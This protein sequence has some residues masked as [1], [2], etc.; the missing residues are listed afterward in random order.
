MNLNKKIISLFF[1][2]SVVAIP[3][4]YSIYTITMQVII[5]TRMHDKMEHEQLLMFTVES[6]SI[7]WL[8]V[9]KEM[10]ING[11][12][13]DVKAISKN[14]NMVI[15]TGLFDAAEKKLRIQLNKYINSADQQATAHKSLLLQ[16]IANYYQEPGKINL[17]IPFTFHK[18]K[19]FQ[20][21]PDKICSLY[22]EI[23]LPPPRLY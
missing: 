18:R 10:L 12:P 23:V 4:I 9:N 11:E 5:E 22:D 3:L 8:K 7:I 1:L 20:F 2:F 19:N 21:L 16:F 17:D 14:G 15:V 13:F 6:S